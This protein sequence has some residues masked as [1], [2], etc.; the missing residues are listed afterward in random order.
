MNLDLA[1]K[2]TARAILDRIREDSRD[3]AE[4][5]RWFLQC[6]CGSRIGSRSS[7]STTSGASPTGPNARR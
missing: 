4:K 2:P 6:S 1:G 7:G 3:E 5:G